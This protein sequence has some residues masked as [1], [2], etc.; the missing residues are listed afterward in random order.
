[1]KGTGIVKL[2]ILGQGLAVMF[3]AIIPGTA[4]A[5][6]ELHYTTAAD[7]YI[8]NDD[9]DMRWD[10][11]WGYYSNTSSGASSTEGSFEF[12]CPQNHLNGNAGYAAG[13]KAFVYDQ[14]NNTFITVALCRVG[15][16]ENNLGVLCDYQVSDDGANNPPPS[17]LPVTL[18]FV[19]QTDSTRSFYYWDVIVP[20]RDTNGGAT[21][22]G[23]NYVSGFKFLDN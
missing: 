18:T 21:G 4:E 3:V 14:S 6:N 11:N 23:Q 8:V 13:S 2:K 17:A 15:G 22:S 10:Y 12:V 19:A 7:C 1:M 5:I 9:T 20:G 16:G